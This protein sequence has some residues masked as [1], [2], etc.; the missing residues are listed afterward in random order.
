MRH[1]YNLLYIAQ[2][3][4]CAQPVVT[5]VEP[6]SKLNKH[7]RL[8]AF[9]NAPFTVCSQLWLYSDCSCY[10]LF[11]SDQSP[12]EKN[13]SG[14]VQQKKLSRF[15]LYLHTYLQIVPALKMCIQCI[16]LYYKAHFGCKAEQKSN[17]YLKPEVNEYTQTLLNALVTS[18]AKFCFQLQ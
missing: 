2:F 1:S 7:V 6:N 3:E 12:G 13:P 5:D 10:E 17:S 14:S 18:I 11:A 15:I 16:Q 9:L 8:S 4:Q